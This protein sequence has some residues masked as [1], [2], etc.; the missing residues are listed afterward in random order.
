MRSCMRRLGLLGTVVVAFVAS[1]AVLAGGAAEYYG[2]AEVVP[3]RV[4]VRFSSFERGRDAA[5]AAI[6]DADE[7]SPRPAGRWHRVHS[8][9][10]SVGSM[11]S[12]L[13]ARAD[14]VWAEPDYVVRLGSAPDD[15]SF[16]SEW[17]LLNTGQSA[18]PAGSQVSGTSGADIGAMV[19][20]NFTTGSRS[21]VVAVI[22]TGITY[23]HPDL[24]GNVWSAPSAYSF[25]VDGTT[26]ACPAGSHG[27]NF[28]AATCDPADD[29]GH[30]T[31][32]SGTIGAV[33]DN[34]VGVTG[35]SQTAS[36]L[37]LKFLDNTGNGAV[38]DAVSAI[39]LAIAIKNRFGSAGNVRVLSASWGG[40][41]FS[42]ALLD[43]VNRAS[44]ADM[45][46]VAAAGN[47]HANN[48]VTQQYPAGYASPNVLS[49]AAS[50]A[51]DRLA[52][53]SDYGATTVHLAAPGVNILST[54]LSSGYD[55][56][57]GTSMATPHVSG[58]AALLLA[59]CSLGTAALR[60]LI[61]QSV[62]K[63]AGLSG[64]VSSGGRLNVG[65][66]M[67]SCAAAATPTPT[68][69]PR[70]TA[71]PT[72]TRVPTP[73]P[74][75]TPTPTATPIPTGGP[76]PTP[77]PTGSSSPGPAAAPAS[78]QAAGG[79]GGG[80]AS[81]GSSLPVDPVLPGVLIGA[82]IAVRRRR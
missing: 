21:T 51:N 71:T 3:Q 65:N 26:I 58:A 73:T 24:V 31:H 68:A 72:P 20:W 77:V 6:P 66:A 37:S 48:D 5:L 9:R 22:D 1:S 34:E 64:L 38:S 49:V 62:D 32:V 46:F 59:K 18:G 17:G 36:I 57:S 27:Y 11:L 76:V 52:N 74:T 63:V 40:T 47:N 60:G 7:V 13:R 81:G 2:G 80:C 53:F 14:V 69:T 67:T 44:A 42:Q 25:S 23:G 19:A 75:R 78:A 56:M 4:L 10:S 79:G 35:V 50:D 70:P 39:D 16:P 28:V 41:S 29:N 61:L 15:P 55:W 45:L 30:G 33:G 8:K 82:W 12:A 43:A 54:Y